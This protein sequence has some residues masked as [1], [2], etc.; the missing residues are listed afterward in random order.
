M[1]SKVIFFQQIQALMTQFRNM[2][3]KMKQKR[4]NFVVTEILKRHYLNIAQDL[5]GKSPFP[6]FALYKH[7]HINGALTT[8][9][10]NMRRKLKPKRCNFEIREI[11]KRHNFEADAERGDANRAFRVFVINCGL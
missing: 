11:L 5:N 9:L 7:F 3:R 4:R 1:K 2:R 10:P 8:Q 6:V